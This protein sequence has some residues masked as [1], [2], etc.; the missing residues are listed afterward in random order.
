MMGAVMGE[1]TVD[2]GQSME[3]K[4]R[5]FRVSKIG[6]AKDWERGS[7]CNSV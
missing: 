2:H 6:M 3:V 1:R 5:N 7:L 4:V